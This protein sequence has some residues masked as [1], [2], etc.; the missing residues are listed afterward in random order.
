M[1]RRK[2]RYHSPAAPQSPVSDTTPISG[3]LDVTPARVLKR[4]RP[5]SHFTS[6]NFLRVT[7]SSSCLTGEKRVRDCPQISVSEQGKLKFGT[8]GL[9]QALHSIS[10]AQLS[11][12]QRG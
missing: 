7:A 3:R 6:E 2:E 11:R 12:Y 9:P 5:E 10:T 8:G 1:R 4:W